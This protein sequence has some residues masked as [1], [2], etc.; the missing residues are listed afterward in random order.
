METQLVRSMTDKKVAGV[1][2]GLAQYFNIDPVFVRLGFVV[3]TLMGG[4][5]PLIYIA[6]WL[7]MPEPGQQSVFD[8]LRT[9]VLGSAGTPT[10]NS[11]KLGAVLVVLGGLMLADMLHITGPVIA[12]G[13]IIGGWYLLRGRHSSIAS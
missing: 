2:G 9:R 4:F 12:V 5:G 11:W 6:L 7:V 8:Q 1:A 10:G 3:L 13:L